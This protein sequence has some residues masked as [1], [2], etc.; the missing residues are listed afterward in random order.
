MRN[1]IAGNPA[2]HYPR[3]RRIRPEAEKSCVTIREVRLGEP[4]IPPELLVAVLAQDQRINSEKSKATADQQPDLV[5]AEIAVQTSQQRA[6]AARNE[7]QGEKDRL[8][9]V[10]EGQKSQA[11]VLGVAE[12]VNLQKY[13]ILLDKVFAFMNANPQVLQVA[14]QNAG[15]LV[16]STY[17]AGGGSGML[18]GILGKF[19]SGA[20]ASEPSAPR[21]TGRRSHRGVA[22]FKRKI[23]APLE[24]AELFCCFRKTV[25]SRSRQNIAPVPAQAELVP[26]D[27]DCEHGYRDLVASVLE[28]VIGI[29]DGIR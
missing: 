17:V 15:K 18:D 10:A 1:D 24:T 23:T 2:R 7:G 13:N 28:H 3:E 4:A 20:D 8:L 6:L 21:T 12:T 19:L 26:G 25:G 22:C 27:D 29:A 5:K 14:L 16:P 9:L 11:E